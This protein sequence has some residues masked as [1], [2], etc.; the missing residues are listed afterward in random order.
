LADH[1][2]RS[3]WV[4]NFLAV[5]GITAEGGHTDGSTSPIEAAATFEASESSIAVICSSD[6]I[7]AARAA[8]TA[9]AL[10]DAGATLVALAGHPG[11]LRDEL[12]AAGVDT[13]FHVGVDVLAALSDLHEHLGIR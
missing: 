4:T 8:A 2:A 6:A 7:Y 10:K 1:T 12:E 13:F 3:T 11:D 9:T 5:G